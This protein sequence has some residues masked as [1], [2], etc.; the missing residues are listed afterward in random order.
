[1]NYTIIPWNYTDYTLDLTFAQGETDNINQLTISSNGLLISTNNEYDDTFTNI[2]SVE[3]ISTVPFTHY[4]LTYTDK[5]FNEKLI[6]TFYMDKIKNSV[7]IF[8]N[9]SSTDAT[10][11]NSFL[12]ENIK[13]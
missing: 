10:K 8:N 4:K 7:V 13:Y 9:V 1:M 2:N 11:I 5:Q 12:N 6:L 3:F